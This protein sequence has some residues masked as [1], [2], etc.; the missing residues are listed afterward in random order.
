MSD[1]VLEN[2][3]K[4]SHS[5]EPIVN[6]YDYENNIVKDP[7]ALK[8]ITSIINHKKSVKKRMLF[9]AKEITKRAEEHDNSKLTKP[10]LFW[11]IQMD[12]EPA[13]KYGTPAYFEKQKRWKKFFQHHYKMNRHHP[14]H[15]GQLGVYG[16]TIVDLVEMMCDVV[17]YC[18]ELHVFQADKIIEEQKRRFGIDENI[19]QIII[20]TLNYYYTWVGDFEPIID[21]P[22]ANS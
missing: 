3:T 11:L 5:N 15:F 2:Y 20:N 16:M 1:N 14:D 6:G 10:E 19:S 22:S 12:K 17:S 9:L 21:E 7:S 8:T 4:F 13:V 18:Q